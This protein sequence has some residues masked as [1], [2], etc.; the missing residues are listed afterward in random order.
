MRSYLT[1]G[2]SRGIIHNMKNAFLSLMVLCGVMLGTTANAYVDRATANVRIMNKAAG[3]TQSVAIP[4]GQTVKFEKLNV[5]VRSCKQTDPFDALDFFA[6]VEITKSDEGLIYSGW[7]S[8]NEPG[9][10]P[11]Q[12]ADYDLWLIGCDADNANTGE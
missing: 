6:F 7:M 12:N 5:T 4:V 1:S 2:P 3:K 9:D 8:R 10:N 11:V